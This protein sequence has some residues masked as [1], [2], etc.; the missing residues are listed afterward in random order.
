LS[1]KDNVTISIEHP[2]D[3]LQPGNEAMEPEVQLLATPT[4]QQLN[5]DMDAALAGVP[6]N[7]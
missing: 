5:D 7:R 3:E 2:N 1:F 4:A 6:V